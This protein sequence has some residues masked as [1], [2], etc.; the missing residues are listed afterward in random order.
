MCQTL[1][2]RCR[3]HHEAYAN[4]NYVPLISQAFLVNA[5]LYDGMFY[6]VAC[7][8]DAPL[9]SADEAAKRS[10]QSVFGDPPWILRRFAANGKK[11][12]SRLSFASLLCRI[13][14]C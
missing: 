8:E 6:A 1:L 9:I 5:G 4:E 12:R 2:P 13:S 14:L 10:E 11:G 7:A 3:V